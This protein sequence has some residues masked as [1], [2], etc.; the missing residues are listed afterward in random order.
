MWI[1]FAAL[2][3]C[4]SVAGLSKMV[5]AAAFAGMV[6]SALPVD[7]HVGAAAA[8]LVALVELL[9]SAIIITGWLGRGASLLAAGMSLG[10]LLGGLLLARRVP[11]GVSC[12]CFGALT[13]R[14]KLGM[15][16]LLVACL[17]TAIPA[18]LYILGW[19]N[20]RPEFSFL[21]ASSLTLV[22]LGLGAWRSVR[23][24]DLRL[25]RPWMS[26]EEFQ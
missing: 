16:Q 2:A 23:A 20:T 12:G 9:V 24:V 22:T 3:A 21:L 17:L 19:R 13:D 11:H 25:I 26:G 5:S 7:E 15:P 18:L 14:M 10:F 1:P 8:R 6:R 4:F